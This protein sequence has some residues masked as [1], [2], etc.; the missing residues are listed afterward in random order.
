M[1]NFVRKLT[2]ISKLRF[3]H[4]TFLFCSDFCAIFFAF[5]RSIIL[6]RPFKSCEKYLIQS[7]YCNLFIQIKQ[8]SQLQ[9]IGNLKRNYFYF[10]TLLFFFTQKWFS[11]PFWNSIICNTEFVIKVIVHNIKSYSCKFTCSTMLQVYPILIFN[12]ILN[13]SFIAIFVPDITRLWKAEHLTTANKLNNIL[14]AMN[15]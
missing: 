13:F 12:I 6:Q 10:I 15:C 8:S 1:P 3:S 5:S 14:P 7:L 9:R 2:K 4:Q 11:A